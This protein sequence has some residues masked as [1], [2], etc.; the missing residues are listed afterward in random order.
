MTNNET[1]NVRGV[2]VTGPFNSDAD[3]FEHHDLLCDLNYVLIALV[4]W[5]S[6]GSHRKQPE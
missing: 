6:E 4:I 1:V 3:F 2:L 5:H